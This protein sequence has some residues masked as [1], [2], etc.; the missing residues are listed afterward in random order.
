MFIIYD[1]FDAALVFRIANYLINLLFSM[2]TKKVVLETRKTFMLLHVR[3][4]EF[5]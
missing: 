3:K 2:S 1:I 4:V 5:L